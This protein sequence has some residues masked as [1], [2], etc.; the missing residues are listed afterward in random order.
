MAGPRPSPGHA[1]A[2]GPQRSA[3]ADAHAPAG[4]VLDSIVAQIQAVILDTLEPGSLL[5]AES[6]LATRYGVSRLTVREAIKVLAGRG[7]IRSQRGRRP[8]VCQPDS[9]ILSAHLTMAARRESRAVLELLEIRAA[10]EVLVAGLA[11]QH[12]T[13]AGT[14][15]IQAALDDMT[16]AAEKIDAG[17]DQPAVVDAYN[18]ADIAFHEAL[19]LA[20]GNRMLSFVLEGFQGP[21]QHSF[22]QSFTGHISR[23]GSVIEV[24]LAHQRILDC[25]RAGD[26]AGA[27]RAMR[28]HLRDTARDLHTAVNLLSRAAE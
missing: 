23:G 14:A 3:A 10:L 1:P 5:P 6:E 28:E 18:R 19:A 4:T 21:L 17:T 8:E 15:A 26:S 16:V 13:R 11:A 7:L 27:Q 25:I 24:V 22:S 20:S 12:M 9:S 2:P